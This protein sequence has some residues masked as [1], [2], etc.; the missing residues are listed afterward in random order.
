MIAG[1]RAMAA[2]AVVVA[3]FIAFLSATASSAASG[4]LDRTFSEDGWV[5]TLE[6]RTDSNNYLPEGA[7][8][9]AV[10]ADGTIVAVGTIED[11]NSNLY[12][13][14][15]R[16]LPDGR[17]D[18]DFGNGGWVVTNIGTF[19]FPRAVALQSDGSIVVA[20]ETTCRF[21]QCFAL[22]RYNPDGSLDR[23]F[24]RDGVV[25]TTFD[26]CRCAANDVAVRQDGTVVAAGYRFK[27]GDH[28]DDALFAVARYL[29][30]GSLDRSFS[31]DGKVSV[32]FGFGDDVAT[33]IALLPR[34]RVL[35]AG[36]GTKN[37]Y[38]TEDDFAVAR[39]RRDGTLDP[40]F[41]SNGLRTLDFGSGRPDFT[42]DVAVHGDGI[43]LAGSTTAGRSHD[44]KIAVARLRGD[45]SLDGGFGLRTTNP[46]S[47]GGYANA[48]TIDQ[49]GRIVVAGAAFEDSERLS[50]DWMLVRHR[51]SGARDDS[52]DGDGVVRT[53]FGSGGDWVGALDVDRAGKIVSG[54]SI[55]GSQGVARYL[56]D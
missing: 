6:V 48:V 19:E 16:Y 40:G 55:Y 29:P 12:F 44:L 23:S 27:Y 10:E 54:G 28:M 49:E 8:D 31:K 13:G 53:D 1:R 24:G 39:F 35:V 38:L 32:D 15:F 45:G 26:Q 52:W 4:D 21:A 5:R 34:G 43:V 17:L 18:P 47:H 51:Q 33:S 20:G 7:T 46:G 50:S 42:N 41:S 3:A 36:S 30:D 14:V 22:V 37:L 11:G 25:K 9:V 56:N 2:L